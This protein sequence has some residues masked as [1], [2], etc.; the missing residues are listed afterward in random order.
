MKKF[1]KA[2][3]AN[4]VG[5][6]DASIEDFA[7][8]VVPVC[9]TPFFDFISEDEEMS[10]T[11]KSKINRALDD[12]DSE[13]DVIVEYGDPLIFAM[14]IYYLAD[15]ESFTI[16]RYSRKNDK[17]TF[18]LLDGWWVDELDDETEGDEHD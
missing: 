1:R 17:Y 10:K 13:K 12:F 11:F 7:E 9:P 2:F 6:F 15:C 18:H 3:I 4:P 16:G 5:R 8:E 14:M